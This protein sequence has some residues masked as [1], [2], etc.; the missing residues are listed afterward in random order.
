MKGKDGWQKPTR[1]SVTWLIYLNEEWDSD[2]HG[3]QLR[4]FERKENVS[5]EVGAKPNGDLQIGWLRASKDDPMERPVFLDGHCAT[6]KEG[7]CAMYIEHPN[8]P[9]D[10][11]YITKTFYAS[12]V[13]F[14]A[15]SEELTKKILIKRPDLASRFHYLEA[16]KSALDTFLGKEDDG[17]GSKAGNDEKAV[18]VPPNGGTLVVFDSVSVP[19]EVLATRDRERW[20][21]SGWWHEDQQNV[22]MHMIKDNI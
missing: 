10:P 2:L 22:P 7:N 5:N 20:A 14:V 21:T 6:N 15:G 3:G 18:L 16:P 19:H 17:S 1:R 8:S 12:P 9:N 13:L 11:L 4:V